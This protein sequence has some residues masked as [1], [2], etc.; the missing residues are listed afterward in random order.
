MNDTIKRAVRTFAQGFVG[1]LAIMLVPFLTSMVSGAASGG[2]VDIDVN[3]LGKVGIAAVAGGV[4][5]LVAFAQN[6]L[7]AKTGTDLLPK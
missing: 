5:A 1:V 7:E 4:I 3:F 2:D 6:V